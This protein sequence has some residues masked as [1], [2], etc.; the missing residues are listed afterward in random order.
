MADMLAAQVDHL[1]PEQR[2]FDLGKLRI[3][4]SRQIHTGYFRAHGGG[5]RQCLDMP[6]T[7]GVIVE[8]AVWM[9]EHWLTPD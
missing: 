7:P 8:L 5:Q 4:Q 1:V 3:I 2:V 9:Q 6:V